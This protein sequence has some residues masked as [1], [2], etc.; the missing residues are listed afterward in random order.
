MKPIKKQFTRLAL[1]SLCLLLSVPLA[2]AQTF[3]TLTNGHGDGPITYGR[4]ITITTTNDST[5]ISISKPAPTNGL[6]QDA[7]DY[8]SGSSTFLSVNAEGSLSNFGTNAALHTLTNLGV[9]FG[10]ITVTGSPMALTFPL[11]YAYGCVP[12]V[13]TSHAGSN[14]L[15][16][17]AVTTNGATLTGSNAASTNA[18]QW[19]SIGE[20]VQTH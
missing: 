12:V 3:G 8:F 1:C 7:L 16:V 20:V 17:S 14:N 2:E 10:G 18:V 19:I 4:N 6:V 5:A 15:W 11:P 13:T 9:Q